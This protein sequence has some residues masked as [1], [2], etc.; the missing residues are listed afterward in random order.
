MSEPAGN[1]IAHTG[2]PQASPDGVSAAPPPPVAPTGEA[3]QTTRAQSTAATASATPASG[4]PASSGTAA[5]GGATPSSGNRHPQVDTEWGT[6]LAMLDRMERILNDAT[7]E[8]GKV[9]IDRAA[10][11]EMRAE[12]AQIRTMLRGS[13]KN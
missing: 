9:N 11:D 10:I 6:A 8:P 7:K 1:P 4:T 5:T 13:I 12:M 3:P 2:R